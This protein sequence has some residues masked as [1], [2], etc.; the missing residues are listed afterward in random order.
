MVV[1]ILAKR[2]GRKTILELRRPEGWKI[3][4]M[5]DWARLR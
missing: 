1:A 2:E 3:G 4:R 5:E